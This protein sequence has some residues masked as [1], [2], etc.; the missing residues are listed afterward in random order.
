MIPQTKFSDTF[1][2]IIVDLNNIRDHI[3]REPFVFKLNAY[4]LDAKAMVRD[5]PIIA[6]TLLGV[7]ANIQKDIEEMYKFHKIALRVSNNNKFTLCNYAISLLNFDLLDESFE[8]FKKALD[9]HNSDP[10]NIDDSIVLDHLMGV[11]Y[12]LH[13]DVEY[14]KYKN[15]LKKINPKL[16]DPDNFPEDNDKT[17]NRLLSNADKIMEE[18]PHLITKPDPELMVRIDKLVEGVDIS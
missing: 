17:L 13:D 7:I 16:I 14:E 9:A 10:L 12:Y 11:C 15:M 1:N 18:N 6:Y 2:D 5:E 8:Y 3:D 4:K